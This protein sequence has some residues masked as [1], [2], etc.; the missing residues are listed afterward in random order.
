MND[1]GS[2]SE[3]G[4]KYWERAKYWADN[5]PTVDAKSHPCPV[6]GQTE[7]E[8]VGGYSICDVCEWED[9][10]IQFNEPDLTGGANWMSLNQA[11][12]HWKATGKQVL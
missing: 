2:E 4:K 1:N 8:P 11:R 9:D 12:S 3:H 10:F 5:S 7:L 6:C